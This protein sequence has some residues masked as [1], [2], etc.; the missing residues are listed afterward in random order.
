MPALTLESSSLLPNL[1]AKRR[2]FF[3]DCT[4]FRVSHHEVLPPLT[5]D[6]YAGYLL[7]TH[8]EGG[9]QERLPD[10]AQSL[11]SI[12]AQFNL[13]IRG[14]IKKFR[15]ENLSHTPSEARSQPQLL[16]GEMPPERFVAREYDLKFL[17]S[18]HSGFA[19]GLFLDI[20][21]ARQR[22]QQITKSGDEV[23]N[24]FSYTGG[25][26]LAAAKAGAARVIEVDSSAH[27]LRWARENQVLNEA[28]TIRQR[29]EDAVAFLHKQKDE[30][31]D[32]I[33][34][35]PPTYS[36]QK[37]GARFTV[38]K[39]FEAMLPDLHRVLRPNGLLLACTNY[40]ELPR[41]K[42]F[43]LF[44]PKFSLQEEIPISEDFDGEDYLKVGLLRKA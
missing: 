39:G 19:S 44:A 5:I 32:L 41:G 8:Y 26:S 28:T 24:L 7:L 10:L 27:W 6:Y 25:F 40:R 29:Q 20:K 1:L 43:K 37:S 2:R 18:F 3:E 34:C 38:A 31:F 9:S 42:F 12:L 36:S 33:I 22:V 13:S 16:F 21:H 35:D 14:A 30:S 15:P 17:V 23:L 4:A 11:A